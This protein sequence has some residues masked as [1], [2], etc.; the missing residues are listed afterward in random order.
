M[1][2]EQDY[3]SLKE[4]LKRAAAV[5]TVSGKKIPVTD[6]ENCFYAPAVRAAALALSPAINSNPITSDWYSAIYDA[7]IEIAHHMPK[8]NEV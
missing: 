2:V 5:G 1:R 8:L 4:D 7:Q 3:R 6:A